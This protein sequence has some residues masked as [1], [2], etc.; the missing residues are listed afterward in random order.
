MGKIHLG[1]ITYNFVT[2]LLVT[3]AVIFRLHFSQMLTRSPMSYAAWNKQQ[4]TQLRSFLPVIRYWL[5]MARLHSS[6][7]VISLSDVH[8]SNN[9]LFKYTNKY[10]T[11]IPRISW[12]IYGNDDSSTVMIKNI[13][14]ANLFYTIMRWQLIETF[15]KWIL[16]K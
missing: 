7:C 10:Y 15:N 5:L 12:V 14:F 16:F 6:S 9:L 13:W 3:I 4:S 8:V 2:W 11:Q 1:W